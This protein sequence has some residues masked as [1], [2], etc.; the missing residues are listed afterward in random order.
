M[1]TQ[2]NNLDQNRPIRATARSATLFTSIVCFGMAV[3]ILVLASVLND[4]R[5]VDIQGYS[6]WVAMALFLLVGMVSVSIL[7]D[8]RYYR[9]QLLKVFLVGYSLRVMAALLIYTFLNYQGLQGFEGNDDIF[10][11]RMARLV[12]NVPWDY[13]MSALRGFSFSYNLPGYIL[14]NAVVYDLVGFNPLVVRL[15][16]AL[17]GAL[18]PIL[19]YRLITSLSNQ[20]AALIAAWWIALFPTQILF[21]ALQQKEMVLAFLTLLG[22][23]SI[24]SLYSRPSLLAALGIF[25][26]VL[27]AAS[28]RTIV[29]DVLAL[30]LGLMIVRRIKSKDASVLK[31]RWILL[32]LTLIAC[33]IVTLG[34]FARAGEG[35]LYYERAIGFVDTLREVASRMSPGG[36]S[37]I[38]RLGLPLQLLVGMAYT[39]VAPFPPRFDISLHYSFQQG[40]ASF[41]S[42]INFI[43]LAFLIR[44]I[45]RSLVQGATSSRAVEFVVLTLPILAGMISIAVIYAGTVVAKRIWFEPV[46]L[47]V[48]AREYA[49]SSGELKR[50]GLSSGLVIAGFAWVA[51]IILR[52]VFL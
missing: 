26:S 25:V 28:I 27:I 21:S 32:F 1:S 15:V 40:I 36:V 41:F 34:L 38:L 7:A 52:S 16:N 48:A 44:W 4:Q 3:A 24:V 50:R 47:A 14:L 8:E 10:W 42:P 17:L 18:C 51:Y 20:R 29:S 13:S 33:A 35:A 49:I 37:L 19:A 31:Q 5:S 22:L 46:F 6:S 39:V 11:D 12:L 23:W 9:G 2:V 45:R 30:V 43:V